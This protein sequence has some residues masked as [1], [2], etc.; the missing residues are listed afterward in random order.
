MCIEAADHVRLKRWVLGTLGGAGFSI[1]ARTTCSSKHSSVNKRK[2][3]KAFHEMVS[4]MWIAKQLNRY[5]M[6][7]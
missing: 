3:A 6:N 1:L 2:L 4:I 7:N 5:N